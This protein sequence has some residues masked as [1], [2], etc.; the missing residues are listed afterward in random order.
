MCS[1]SGSCVSAALRSRNATLTSCGP[2]V[3]KTRVRRRASISFGGRRHVRVGHRV[4]GLAADLR[5]E[6]AL[7]IDRDLELV[8]P[9]E[10]RHVA[11]DV[12]QQEHVEVV[13]GVERKVVVD[14]NSAARAERQT[15]D[16]LRLRKIRRRPVYGRHGR[17]G[18]IA[19]RERRDLRRRGQILLE[20][21]GRYAQDVGDVVE[22][23][24][25]VVGRQE[26]G[27]IDVER[28]QIAH[29]VAVLGSIQAMDGGGAGIR[30]G[31][32]G[33]VEPLLE[34]T[35]E[36]GSCLVV[37][38]RL[39]WRR[40]LPATQLARDFLEDLLVL[41][42]LLKVDILE[43]QAARLA[44]KVMAVDAVTLD[45]LG[46]A[47]R[48]LLGGRLAAGGEGGRD[49]G[50]SY[51]EGSMHHLVIPGICANYRARHP[52]PA[53]RR[54]P[55]FCPSPP[56]DAAGSK[57]HR[58][59]ALDGRPPRA[60]PRLPNSPQ[61]YIVAT[62]RRPTAPPGPPF[63]LADDDIMARQRPLKLYR[64][65]GIIAHIDAG[66]TTTTE[67]VLYYTGKKHQIIE[68]HDTKDR[69][70]QHDDRLPGAGA[71]ARHHDPE[72]RRLGR[73][74]RLPDQ[75]H[76]HARATSTSRSR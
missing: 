33:R 9:L 45:D 60:R 5:E 67:R 52:L 18:R 23:V 3:T 10:P 12:A 48:E 43:R 49:Q 26:L 28:E 73:V 65:I 31:G 36:T 63:Q 44:G 20:Q 14:Q 27:R 15:L 51:A 4:V 76:R 62:L 72:R 53:S 11:H 24:A 50:P 22:T 30:R 55:N 29:G 40:H 37:G 41:G 75:H 69:Q 64:N 35:D 34:I 2:A 66:K 54:N 74:E 46:V 47:G 21:R 32:G 38:L 70:G 57:A 61:I 56:P 25:L 71:Q 39:A 42:H 68:V 58:R 8:R 7:A 19:H 6:H 17:R 1:S 59:R 16:V 13:L